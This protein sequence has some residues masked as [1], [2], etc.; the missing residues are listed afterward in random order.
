MKHLKY[1]FF[2]PASLILLALACNK[3]SS[4]TSTEDSG[5]WIPRGDADAPLRTQPA[6][7]TIGNTAY[8]GT[9]YDGTNRLQDFWSIDTI[10]GTPLLTWNQVAKFPGTPRSA[11][12]G[13]AV[14]GKGYV[15][16]GTDGNNRL[17]DTWEFNPVTNQWVQKRD[18]GDTTGSNV[19]LNNYPGTARYGASAF[20]IGGKG[21]VT[22]GYDGNYQKDLFEYNP[23]ND[24]WVR[25]QSLGGKGRYLSTVWV[26]NG[27]A[28]VV[29]G[30]GSSGNLNDLW[31]YNP[32]SNTWTEKRKTTNA[33]TESYDDDY[34]DI[35]RYGAV[36]F[37]MGN[38][39]YLS[40]GVISSYT[41][42]TWEYD[43]TTDLWTR[44][45]PFERLER[46]GSVAFTLNGR[47]FITMG[48]SSSQY[49]GDVEEFQPNVTR[50]DDY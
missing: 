11:A 14:N 5:N 10:A 21:Y 41:K 45:T 36:S 40:L 27:L 49:F 16:T 35:S 8:V 6:S 31:A 38:K 3:S 25:K 43:F 28:Y 39:G 32:S 13:F 48:K 42:K 47:G 1:F 23:T 4:S 44:K 24:T 30:L 19:V 33:S 20:S 26:Y 18:F 7:F 2:L 29:S 37:V 12:A 22:S 50:T 15:T 46:E 17:K 9:G 34:S